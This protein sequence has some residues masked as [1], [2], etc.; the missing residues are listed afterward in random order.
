MAQVR[1]PGFLPSTSGLHFPNLYPHEPE[2][3]VRLPLGRTLPLGETV[4][5]F[6]RTPYTPQEP[7]AA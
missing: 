2:L 4:Y 7:P 1:V 5:C 6:F 3:T